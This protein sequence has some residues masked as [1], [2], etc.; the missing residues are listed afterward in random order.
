MFFSDNASDRLLM[1]ALTTC[2][3]P[4]ACSVGWMHVDMV[5]LCKSKESFAMTRLAGAYTMKSAA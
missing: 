2:E 3:L 1:S 5:L 4:S